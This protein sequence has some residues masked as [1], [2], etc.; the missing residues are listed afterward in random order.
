MTFIQIE[1]PRK[2]MSTLKARGSK[3]ELVEALARVMLANHSFREIVK[4]AND[5][6]DLETE[7]VPDY[8]NRMTVIDNGNPVHPTEN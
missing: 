7:I 1:S 5:L 4:L 6:V 8:A 2:N 3:I